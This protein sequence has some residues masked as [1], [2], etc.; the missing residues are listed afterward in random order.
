[1]RRAALAAGLVLC[2]CG[3]VE[4]EVPPAPV[5]EV[6]VPRASVADQL[7]TD[8]AELR[9][10]APAALAS[11]AQRRRKAAAGNG[12]RDIA[13]VRAAMA[14]A[15]LPGTDEDEILSLV[16]P[17]AKR[18]DADRETRAMASFLQAMAQDRR[19]LKESAAAAGA[20]LRDERRVQEH[21]KSRADAAEERAAALQQKLDGLTEL[22]KSLSERPT[23]R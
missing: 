16:E 4:P 21:L 19:R 3:T 14:L 18:R 23:S 12:A 10:M 17:V 1:M 11:E 8:L 20:R 22:E 5:R 15:L 13:R 2:A 9:T 7:L 6:A